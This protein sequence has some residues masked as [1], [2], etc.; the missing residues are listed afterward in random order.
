MALK[1][2]DQWRTESPYDN[3]IDWVEHGAKCPKCGS[4]QFEVIGSCADLLEL[5]LECSDCMKQWVF[6]IPDE[7]ID[8]DV[9]MEVIE[10]G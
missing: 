6:E 4:N 8:Y 5:D 10:N 1:S 9:I 3:D 2:Y 7:L